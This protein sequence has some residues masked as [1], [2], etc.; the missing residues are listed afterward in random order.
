MKANTAPNTFP[1]EVTEP[2]TIAT[3][4]VRLV[5]DAN[6]STS[7]WSLGVV[8][9][10]A[11][12]TTDQVLHRRVPSDAFP[13]DVEQT[14][15]AVLTRS[16]RADENHAVG[17]NNR[18]RELRAIFARLEPSQALQVRRRLDADRSDD[19]LAAAFR[20]IVV[21]RRQRLRAFLASPRRHLG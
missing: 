5:A 16:L 19:P 17:N 8:A 18:E 11:V 13:A 7:I 21:E 4:R 9:S 6:V 12:P 3:R 20:R 14:I 2:P 10:S 1:S 15:I